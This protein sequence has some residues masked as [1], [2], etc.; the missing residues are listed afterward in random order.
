MKDRLRELIKALAPRL[1]VQ[2]CITYW[3]SIE[4]SDSPA[5]LRELEQEI[6]AYAAG[7]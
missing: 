5:T 1:P 7:H 3:D 2:F 4:F 6:R